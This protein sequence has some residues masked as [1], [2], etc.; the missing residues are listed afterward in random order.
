[1]S[2]PVL[3]VS[4][5]VDIPLVVTA[6]DRTKVTPGLLGFLVVAAL[7]V[8]TW[9]LVRSMRRH[10]GRIDFEEGG[11]FEEA[12]DFEEP[13]PTRTRKDGRVPDEPG[14]QRSGGTGA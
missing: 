4:A 7:A 6:L 10:L 5:A 12:G 3:F 13:E 1:M 11:D 9:L 2:S 8:A 14:D